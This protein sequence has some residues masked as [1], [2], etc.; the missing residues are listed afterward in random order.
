MQD[1]GCAASSACDPLG[2]KLTRLNVAIAWYRQ[3]DRPSRQNA[4]AKVLWKVAA[5]FR[6]RISTTHKIESLAQKNIQVII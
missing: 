3:K 4:I 2:G 6:V 1:Q 5:H